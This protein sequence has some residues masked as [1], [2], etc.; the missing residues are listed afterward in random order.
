MQ[1]E[2][3]SLYSDFRQ[4][5]KIAYLRSEND[6]VLLDRADGLATHL[7]NVLVNLDMDKEQRCTRSPVLSS[8]LFNDLE[9]RYEQ[10]QHHARSAFLEALKLRRELWGCRSLRYEYEF[11]RINQRFDSSWMEANRESPHI[12]EERNIAM[13]ILPAIWS[14]NV[15]S[16]KR[17][18]HLVAKAIVLL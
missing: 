14:K 11:P 10:W 6:D 15:F 8:T 3:P 16:Q 18:R 7:F 2:C 9:V 17:G 12:V 1:T 4:L 13:G 5:Q